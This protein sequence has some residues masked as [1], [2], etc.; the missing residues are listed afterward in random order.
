MKEGTSTHELPEDTRS[1]IR[2]GAGPALAFAESL[3]DYREGDEWGWN[4]PED[5]SRFCMKAREALEADP[6]S[7]RVLSPEAEEA[8]RRIRALLGAVAALAVLGSEER[9]QVCRIGEGAGF[10][11]GTHP[12]GADAREDLLALVR[13]ARSLWPPEG[14]VELE[15]VA[16]V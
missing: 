2:S 10:D 13:L 5:V 12:M 9:T 3:R 11:R 15:V 14:P 6:H 1:I 16:H 8:Y 4:I 7:T